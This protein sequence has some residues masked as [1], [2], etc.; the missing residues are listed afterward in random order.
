MSN[1][2]NEFYLNTLGDTLQ[3]GADDKNGFLIYIKKPTTT[4][5][6]NYKKP[7][8]VYPTR[9]VVDLIP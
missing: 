5:T 1:P 9:V 3:A 7:Y 6:S 2:N 4:F 8:L